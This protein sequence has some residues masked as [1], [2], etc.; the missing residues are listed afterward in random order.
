MKNALLVSVLFLFLP[1]C[2]RAQEIY[3]WHAFEGFLEEKFLEIVADFNHHLETHQVIPVY[4]GNYKQTY[5]EGVRSFD[6]GHPPHLLQ[7]YEVAT[8][9]MML[10]FNRYVPVETIMKDYYHNFDPYVYI[11]I[12]RHFYSNFEEEL[13]SLPWNASTGILFYNK[14][15]FRQ[16]GLDPERPPRTWLELEEMGEKLIA[17][18]YQGFTTAWPAAYHLEHLSSWHDIPFGTEENG[19]KSLSGRLIF[20]QEGQTFHW[21]KLVEWQQSGLFSYSGRYT[22]EPE[23]KFTD[24]QCAILLQGANRLP[25]LNRAAD[26]EIGVGFMP[27]WPHLAESTHNLNIGGASFWVMQ[28]FSESEYRAIAQFFEY[29]SSPAVQANWHQATGYLPITDA[30][31]YLTKKRGFYQDHPAHEIAVLEV[32]EKTPTSYSRG[33][34]FGNYV[35]IRDLI[36]D[37]LEK[38]LA[39]E[40]TSEDALHQAANEGNQLLEEFEQNYGSN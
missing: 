39:G 16:A 30:A 27:Y 36:T 8:L 20:D 3:L 4:K 33:A 11:D 12:V 22:A 5:E 1:L 13:L 29:L 28:G 35:E 2:I 17:A 38:A 25:L 10:D 31:Y 14:E 23:Q 40:L 32:M 9:S 6:E 37:Y 15:A 18:G 24:G 34:R 7:V 26:F 19:F 21:Q